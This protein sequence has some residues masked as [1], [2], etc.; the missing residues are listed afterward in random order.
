MPQS[1]FWHV[2]LICL[3]LVGVLASL[4]VEYTPLRTA[5]TKII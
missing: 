4:E 5:E 3:V 2:I 1:L